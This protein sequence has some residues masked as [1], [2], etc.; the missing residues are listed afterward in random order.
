MQN[1][2]QSLEDSSN[3]S[4]GIEESALFPSPCWSTPRKGIAPPLS[5]QEP[6]AH[7][8]VI[9]CHSGAVDPSRPLT[10]SSRVTNKS[11][12]VIT[13]LPTPPSHL[14]GADHQE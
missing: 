6:S 12:K 3:F 4:C 5:L 9:L 8:E 1:V 13:V 10:I 7:Y 2:K 11:S 14:G